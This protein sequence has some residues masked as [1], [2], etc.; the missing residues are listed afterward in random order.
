MHAVSSNYLE[1]SEPWD[2]VANAVESASYPMYNSQREFENMHNL[3]E[4]ILF[5]ILD[6][7]EAPRQRKNRIYFARTIEC[8][9]NICYI[10]ATSKN[11]GA[12]GKIITAE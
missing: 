3:L 10:R 1:G 5:S 6:W 2:K 4:P 9:G 8:L 11:D 7:D 12:V